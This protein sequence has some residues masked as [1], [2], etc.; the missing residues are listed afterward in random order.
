[1]A[2]IA[3][4]TVMCDDLHTTEVKVVSPVMVKGEC[5]GV[6]GSSADFCDECGEPAYVMDTVTRDVPDDFPDLNVYGLTLN[7]EEAQ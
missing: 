1:M 2:T 4:A 6:L 5:W 3:V 7:G